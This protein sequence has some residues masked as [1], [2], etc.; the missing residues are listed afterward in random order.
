MLKN[1]KSVEDDIVKCVRCG[2]CRHT[3]P[4]FRGSNEET[5]LCRGRII[6][7]YAVEK[8]QFPLS[9]KFAELIYL[10]QNCD[11]C[12]PTCPTGT[13]GTKI[14][15]ASRRD[16]FELL[17]KKELVK[18][19]YNASGDTD[20]KKLWANVILNDIPKNNVWHTV[21]PKSLEKL[22]EPRFNIPAA[23]NPKANVLLF[24]DETSAYVYP[25]IAQK[26]INV[27]SSVD[28]Q[29]HI[30]KTICSSGAFF[31]IAG[32][33]ETAKLVASKNLEQL[34]GKYDTIVTLDGVSV[35]MLTKGYK[36]LF[37]DAKF[38]N[39]K[40]ESIVSYICKMGG[41][42]L[43]QNKKLNK[44]IV[45]ISSGALKNRLS[46]ADATASLLRKMGATVANLGLE[47]RVFGDE[48]GLLP[49]TN[50]KMVEDVVKVLKRTIAGIGPDMVVTLSPQLKMQLSK[51]LDVP[52]KHPI[53]LL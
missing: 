3:C 25:H 26:A 40:V 28:I 30:P 1:L 49:I 31:M 37:G 10:C 34:E 44:N 21:L 17:D 18:L 32:D 36:E 2:A 24:I 5:K 53:E 19:I 8:S 35:W 50:W 48:F 46:V 38:D 29:V 7:S 14:I 47:D 9:K 16:C 4:T 43:D 45:V 6:L 15:L 22:P 23:T 12:T 13:P 27:L 33:F 52:V 41:E 20:E 42:A 11:T 51:V 39:N